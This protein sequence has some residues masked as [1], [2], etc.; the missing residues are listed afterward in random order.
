[1]T[2]F[3]LGLETELN[4]EWQSFANG[5]FFKW[6]GMTYEGGVTDVDDF[7][8]G[9]IH[10]SG[11]KFGYQEQ[12]IFWQAVGR[13]LNHKIHEI[14][15]RWDTETVQ[16]PVHIRA[17]SIDG[18]ER[19]LRRFVAKIIADGVDTDRR[20]RG[21]GFPESVPKYD[22][23]GAEGLAMAE[24]TR[25][26]QAHRALLVEKIPKEETKA[27]PRRISKS[28]EEFYANNSGLIW[29]W[30]AMVTMVSGAAWL[31]QHFYG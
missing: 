15:K 4:V 3:E 18:T 12:Q 1:V 28:L 14:F 8:G 30:G 16:Y 29:L 23:S 2:P 27:P 26:A 9:R 17:S 25:L 11:I 31:W 22:S 6:H 5:W 20:L 21:R 13:Y 24:I 10:Y 7:R 19:N